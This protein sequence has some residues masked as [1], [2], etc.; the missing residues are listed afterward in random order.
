M[1]RSLLILTACSSLTGYRD[2]PSV[3]NGLDANQDH[4]LSLTEL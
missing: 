3:F 1:I 4:R 2:E